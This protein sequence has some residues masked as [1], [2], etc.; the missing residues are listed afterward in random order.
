VMMATVVAPRDAE[1]AARGARREA[2][3]A[4]LNRASGVRT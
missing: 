1:I 4:H 3:I 2:R